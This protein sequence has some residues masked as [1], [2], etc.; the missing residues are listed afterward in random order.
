MATSRGERNPC[1]FWA[2]RVTINPRIK[3]IPSQLCQL[4]GEWAGRLPEY[5]AW[6]EPKIDGIRCLWIDGKLMTRER[7]P[8]GGVGHIEH[9]LKAIERAHGERLFFDGEFIV[10]GNL[11]DTQSHLN[12]GLRAPEQGTLYLFDVMPL[13][14]WQSDE[15]EAPHCERRALLERLLSIPD[16]S[17]L[18]WEWREGT[19]GREPVEPP[20]LLMNGEWC[21]NACDV[22]RMARGIWA[23]GGEG[24]MVKDFDAPYQRKRSNAWQKYKQ[25]GW[26][27]RRK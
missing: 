19:R 17:P 3:P 13:S 7:V 1:Y 26:S 22:E 2:G 20:V 23:Q 15:S 12:R 9:R 5:G 10:N 8:I 18:T 16:D 6:V 14:L 11:P 27:T 4:A 24:V 21:F 25:A